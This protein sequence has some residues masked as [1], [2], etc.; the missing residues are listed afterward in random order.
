MAKQGRKGDAAK[1]QRWRELVDRCRQSGQT[2]REF[3]H[4]AGVK[5]SAFYWWRRTLARCRRGRGGHRHSEAGVARRKRAAVT[6]VREGQVAPRFLPVQV[7]MD[8]GRELASGVEIHWGN[9]RRVR[10]CRQFDAPTLA[11]VLAV[12]EAQPC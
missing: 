2:V 1:R 8:E 11:A 6:T 3:C 9:G 10:L 12:L 7:V 5:E 4:S